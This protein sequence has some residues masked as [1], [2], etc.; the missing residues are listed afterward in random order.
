[1]CIGK[2][3]SPVDVFK[4]ALNKLGPT[5]QVNVP[6][7]AKDCETVGWFIVK[8]P[9]DV[10]I[11]SFGVV[12]ENVGFAQGKIT[13]TNVWLAICPLGPVQVKTVLVE[14]IDVF[15]GN[16]NTPVD[17]LRYWVKFVGF[18]DHTR[19][20]VYVA[21][22]FRVGKFVEY[23]NVE[24]S[25]FAGTVI[26]LVITGVSHRD[27]E[28]VR[29]ANNPVGPVALIVKL[30]V[31][32]DTPCGIVKTPET[33]E[34]YWANEE[35]YQINVPVVG[36]VWFGVKTNGLIAVSLI[37]FAIVFITGVAQGVEVN[38][39]DVVP[40]FPPG[41]V[42]VIVTVVAAIAV[43]CGMVMRP[44]DAFIKDTGFI[45][46]VKVPTF[47]TVWVGVAMTTS[48]APV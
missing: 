13:D 42:A 35:M 48:L 31:D 29:V 26:V 1:V 38:T 9:V 18:T 12:V 41:P 45:V 6:V 46:Q 10:F 43:F 27:N 47:D 7:W 25:V 2:T 40:N 17:V 11:D 15:I 23:E 19:V 3:K 44:V 28:K 32:I 5:F 37:W 34:K 30:V 14:L 36:A 4:Y 21:E 24:V 39:N 22:W 33:V 8:D 20:P 16:V